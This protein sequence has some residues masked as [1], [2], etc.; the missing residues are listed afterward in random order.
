MHY[1][2]SRLPGPEQVRVGSLPA[3][4]S[5]AITLKGA[6]HPLA[7][8]ARREAASTNTGANIARVSDCE[9]TPVVAI[10]SP[11][12]PRFNC[13][14]VALTC[15]QEKKTEK[16]HKYLSAIQGQISRSAVALGFPQKSTRSF[17]SNVKDFVK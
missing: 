9:N 16:K 11:P 6:P 5:G 2:K 13:G 8:S 7:V 10:R 14:V 12:F 15:E 17:P 1:S 3:Q 4:F